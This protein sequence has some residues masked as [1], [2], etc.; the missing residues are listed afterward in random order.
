MDLEVKKQVHSRAVAGNLQ[1][2]GKLQK[3]AKDSAKICVFWV[4]VAYILELCMP[5]PKVVE[6]LF[7]DQLPGLTGSLRC[8]DSCKKR[9]AV[10]WTSV[11]AG[12]QTRA[13]PCPRLQRMPSRAYWH[14]YEIVSLIYLLRCVKDA[15]FFYRR[16]RTTSGRAMS[17]LFNYKQ[18]LAWRLKK[19]WQ[20]IYAK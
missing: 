13:G 6:L 4:E 8:K 10:R 11:L 14:L 16:W 20:T 12:L 3:V 2:C 5:S 17:S 18:Q 9:E 1:A 19:R 7:R 15:V